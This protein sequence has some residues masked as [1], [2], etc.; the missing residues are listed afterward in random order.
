M[1]SV[2]PVSTLSTESVGSRRELVANCVHTADVTQL[3]SFVASASAMCIGLYRRTLIRWA[4]SAPV[5]A[6]PSSAR[7]LSLL[8]ANDTMLT[9][10]R[11][12]QQTNTTDRNISWRR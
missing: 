8:R 6:R 2:W 11:T 10:E 3:D 9:N 5:F 4:P 1:E 7:A 12:N